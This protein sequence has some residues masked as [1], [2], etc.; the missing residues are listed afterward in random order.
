M[1]IEGMGPKV[2][3]LQ[4]TKRWGNSDLRRLCTLSGS[5]GDWDVLLASGGEVQFCL[6]LKPQTPE[7]RL[8]LNRVVS[9]PPLCSNTPPPLF[10]SLE[11]QACLAVASADNLS[12]FCSSEA[13]SSGQPT[14]AVAEQLKT[15]PRRLRAKAAAWSSLSSFNVQTVVQTQYCAV[16]AREHPQRAGLCAAP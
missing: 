13:S 8:E 16:E 15:T 4:Y 3:H 9:P 11:D 5:P 2:G 12:S 7:S 1:G 10:K 6:G 14:A